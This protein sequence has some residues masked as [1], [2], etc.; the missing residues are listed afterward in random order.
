MFSWCC[1]IV[2][3][4]VDSYAD[5]KDGTK[6]VISEEDKFKW[7]QVKEFGKPFWLISISCVAVYCS[8]FPYT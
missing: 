4:A 7:S 8:I 2:L 6:A 3:C 5:K 1:G